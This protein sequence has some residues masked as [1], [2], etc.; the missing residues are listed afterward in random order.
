MAVTRGP[1]SAYAPVSSQASAVRP[2]TVPSA[3]AAVRI[4]QD[5]LCRRV[6]IID[7]WTPLRIRT[8]RPALRAM[9]AVSGSIL[10]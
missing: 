2:R 3:A 6:V 5:M 7:S 4:R 9:A 8:G 10:V 1:L